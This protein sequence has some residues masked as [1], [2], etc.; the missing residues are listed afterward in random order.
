MSK[1][2]RK[3]RNPHHAVTPKP[4]PE[5]P[6]FKTP[7]DAVGTAQTVGATS[8]IKPMLPITPVAEA[9]PPT[10][11]RGW[12]EILQRWKILIEIVG[13]LFAIFY[14]CV[15]Y[16][17]WEDS[18][19]SIK[20]DERAWVAPVNFCLES[21]RPQTNN[22]ECGP[23]TRGTPA[24]LRVIYKNTGK[25]IAS[26]VSTCTGFFASPVEPRTIA[27]K[28]SGV[29]SSALLSPN[30]VWWSGTASKPIAAE[31]VEQ[32]GATPLYFSGILYYTDIFGTNHWMEF[33]QRPITRPDEHGLLIWF[34]P[35][36]QFNDCDDCR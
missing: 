28:C 11:Q 8:P 9:E 3:P 21:G 35:S 6:S 17:Q 36:S 23:Y 29:R 34:E 24:I 12:Y 27:D 1:G 18:R 15:T 5:D 26:R 7:D 2:H 14:A 4:A 10:P 19:D 30:G 20:L 16:R 31:R 32:L 33:C 25:T 22:N 13:I